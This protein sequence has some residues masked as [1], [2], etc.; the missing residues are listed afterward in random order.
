MGRQRETGFL[1]G[2]QETD[3]PPRRYLTGEACW[4]PRWSLLAYWL[5]GDAPAGGP[6]AWWS[7]GPHHQRAAPASLEESELKVCYA[8][9]PTFPV[10]RGGPWEPSITTW[11]APTPAPRGADSPPSPAPCITA[12]TSCQLS[13]SHKPDCATFGP[14]GGPWLPTHQGANSSP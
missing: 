7:T 6:T 1:S 11:Q 5:L 12:N 4:P 14:E 10:H 8:G 2:L 3:R 13:S 9:D